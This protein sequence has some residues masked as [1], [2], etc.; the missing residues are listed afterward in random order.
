MKKGI[1]AVSGG[2]DSMAMLDMLRK[3]GVYSLFVAHVNYQKRETAYRD[4]KI[5]KEYC[6]KYDIPFKVLYPEYDSGNFQS[7]AREVR[8]QFFKEYAKEVGAKF[9]FVAH[10]MDDLLETYIFQK[11]RNMVCDTF[12]LAVRSSRSGYEIYRPLLSYEKKEL[13]QYCIENEIPYGIDES[14]LTNHYTR[15]QIR[16]SIIDTM[17]RKEKQE[18]VSKIEEENKIWQERRKKAMCFQGNMEDNPDW[19]DLETYLFSFTKKHYSKKHMNSLL[20]QLRKNILVSI[21]GYDVENYH[22]KLLVSKEGSFVYD[23][24]ERL[25]YVNKGTYIFCQNGKTI[26]SL[27][28]REEDF[29]LVVRTVKDTDTIQLR[30]G[31]KNVHRFFV[32]R[33]IP[34]SKRKYWLV[35]ENSKKEIIFVPGI[36][37]NVSHFGIKPN[38][39][40][41]QCNL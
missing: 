13:E 32:D 33:K 34:K 38:L 1:V 31:K 19:L 40:M 18:M 8:Y 10:Q 14:N 35:V 4:E 30:I 2:P 7:W 5:V 28:V 26:E 16:H 6:Q 25:S 11:R 24:Y 27:F 29:P 12:G 39:F 17:S 3:E 15:N 21:D 23:V 20:E 41:L 37:C 36:G 9:L 22:G